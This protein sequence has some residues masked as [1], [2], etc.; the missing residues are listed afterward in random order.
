M[1]FAADS[2]AD[3]T[4][5]QAV[6]DVEQHDQMEALLIPRRREQLV[7]AVK[8]LPFPPDQSLR[9]IDVGAGSGALSEVLLETNPETQLVAVVPDDSMLK[10]AC[11]RLARFGDTVRLEQRGLDDPTWWSGLGGEFDAAISSHATH[12]MPDEDK[13]RVYADICAMLNP[14]GVFV[15]ADRVGA[16]DPRLQ[17]AL[18]TEW[19]R[20]MAGQIR[21][22]LGEDCTAE[23]VLERQIETDAESAA[24]PATV[25]QNL[26]WL[27]EAGFASA[28]CAWR[29]NV[30]AV[31]IA[32]KNSSMEDD[33]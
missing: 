31:L 28:D 22:I 17:H 30:R 8:A 16:A 11:E 19:A 2:N 26:A 3:Q 7:C 13:G 15:N 21:D 29:F 27:R 1:A 6:R 12:R 23:Q 10:L 32:F 5:W 18:M 25:E 20:F 9:V 33:P 14:A 24:C 4:G